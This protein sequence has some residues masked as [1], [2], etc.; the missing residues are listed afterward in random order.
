M[1]DH[2][3]IPYGRPLDGE[4]GDHVLTPFRVDDGTIV[5]V[6]RGL[7]AVPRR[8]G[9]PPPKP[10]RRRGP[11]P[12]RACCSPPRRA[13]RSRRAPG[14]IVRALDPAAIAD[15]TGL[16]L[17]PVSL[18]MTAQVPAQPQGLP[19]PA[20]LPPRDEGPHLSYAVQWFSFAAITLLGYVLLAR[21]DRRAVDAG[22]E[23]AE[24]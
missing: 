3:L 20:P 7:G 19:A 11:P 22:P 5:L 4:P 6:D 9:G 17:A 18:A 21:R 8:R 14:T 15:V 10:P 24:R 23:G 12:S 2:E 1:R 16:E 13:R